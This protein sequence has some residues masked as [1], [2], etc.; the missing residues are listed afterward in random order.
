MTESL[1][2]DPVSVNMDPV[3]VNMDSV[4]RE[5]GLEQIDKG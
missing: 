3:S 5:Y 1:D 4:F 2:P